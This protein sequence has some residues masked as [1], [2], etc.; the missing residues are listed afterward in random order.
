MDEL[1]HRVQFGTVNNRAL[2]SMR[3]PTHPLATRPPATRNPEPG[4]TRYTEAVN[5]IVQ[6]LRT[7]RA[8]VRECARE[9]GRDPLSVQIL[10]VSKM[11]PPAAVREAWDAGQR[12]FGENRVQEA[13][14]KVRA[15]PQGIEWHLIGPLQSNKARKAVEIF[16]VIQTLDR[17]KIIHRV[18]RITQDLGEKI[19]V[20]LEVNV[21]DEIQ[22]HGVSPDRISTL[23]EIVDQYPNLLFEGLMCIPPYFPDPEQARPFFH[24][25]RSLLERICD[26]GSASATQLSMGMSQDYAIAIQ[27]GATVIRVGTS[28]F[29]PRSSPW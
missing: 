25:L 14:S 11:F 1:C 26:S 24:R 10:A 17:P 15:C 18:G 4:T 3:G 22:K 21:G 5:S 2:Q 16:D 20:Y 8:R 6:N 23:L 12:L 7:L 13:A 9:S 19:R 29:G 27:E 28:I